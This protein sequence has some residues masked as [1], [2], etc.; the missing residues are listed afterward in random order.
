M[1]Y[2]V[3]YC[4]TVNT[5]YA[6]FFMT[7]ITSEHILSRVIKTNSHTSFFVQINKR[8]FSIYFGY[9]QLLP[10]HKKK[11]NPFSLTILYYVA[12]DLSNSSS[13]AVLN[14]T[15]ILNAFQPWQITCDTSMNDNSL[16]FQA[17]NVLT[18][19]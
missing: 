5:S 4:R 15:I 8:L 19:L 13:C 17:L 10:K 7:R 16:V 2:F 9:I 14:R 1:I 3:F 18:F 12:F 11:E 6:L